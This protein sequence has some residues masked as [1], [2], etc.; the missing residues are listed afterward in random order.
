[1]YEGG[2]YCVEGIDIYG[3]ADT[4]CATISVFDD[5]G[6]V[7]LPKAFTPNGDGINDIFLPLGPCIQSIDFIIFDRWGNKVFQTNDKT[8]GWDGKY[9]GV[10]MPQ[11]VYTWHL[12]A[13]SSVGRKFNLKGN[14]TLLR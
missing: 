1:M 14:V 12:I 5:C 10:E 11:E 6:F 9:Q 3:C 2:E 8:F 13:T 7:G 4:A